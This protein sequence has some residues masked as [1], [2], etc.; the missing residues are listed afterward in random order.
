[1]KKVVLCFLVLCAALLRPSAAGA[2]PARSCT[3]G[4]AITGIEDTSGRRFDGVRATVTVR[5]AFAG[6]EQEHEWI[7]GAIAIG[8]GRT[9]AAISL[10]SDGNGERVFPW[11]EWRGDG[12]WKYGP[13]NAVSRSPW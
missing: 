4:R 9:Y 5:S 3:D 7:S 2:R 12:Q 11:I 8:L 1:M 10:R 6:L 13:V